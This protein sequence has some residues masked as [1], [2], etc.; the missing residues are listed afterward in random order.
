MF[1]VREVPWHGKG[2]IVEDALTA[3][4]AIKEAG[5]DWTVSLQPVTWAGI[6]LPDKFAVI[7]DDIRAAS[8]SVERAIENGAVLGLVGSRYHPIQNEDL[9]TFFD[10]V[11]DRDKGAFY[12]TGGAL[13]GGRKVWFLAKIPGDFYVPGVPDD[14]VENYLLMASSHDASMGVIIKNTRVRVVCWNTLSMALSGPGHYVH[15]KH[16]ESA[17][18]K[19]EQAHTFFD[20]ATKR[21]SKVKEAAEALLSFRVTGKFMNKFLKVLLPSSLE[22]EGEEAAAKTLKKRERIE[23]LFAGAETNNLTGM[24]GTGWALYNAAAEYADHDMPANEETDT[25][26][27]TWFGRGEGFK[28]QAFKLVMEEAFGKDWRDK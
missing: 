18:Q 27:R 24:R 16:T 21:T 7:R 15:I 20:L 1:S 2:K 25:L 11:V 4:E 9:F 28:R 17:H 6:D 23:I 5:L 26:D 8:P 12:H 22:D 3:A 19:L 13:L 10:P 14:L